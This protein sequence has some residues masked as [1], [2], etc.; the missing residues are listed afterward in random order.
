MQLPIVSRSRHDAVLRSN[1]SL[2]SENSR[3]SSELGKS[4]SEAAAWRVQYRTI[5][6]RIVDLATDERATPQFRAAL[7]E[8]TR[9]PA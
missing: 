5:R 4:N 3:L 8:F 7:A 2:L 9:F 6:D 1:V